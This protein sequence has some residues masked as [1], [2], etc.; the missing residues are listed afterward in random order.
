MITDWGRGKGLTLDPKTKK[1]VVYTLAKVSKEKAFGLAEEMFGRFRSALLDA[2]DKPDV[3][4]QPL[5]EKEIDGRRV[6]GFRVNTRV[7]M[8]EFVGRSQNRPA[9]PR[10]NDHGHVPPT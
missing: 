8:L 7:I 6:V 2:R 3:G 9:G 1:A 5:G 10:G 4:R